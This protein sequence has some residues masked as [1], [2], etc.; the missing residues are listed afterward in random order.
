MATY[1]AIA[2]I[3]AAILAVLEAARPKPEFERATF[4]AFLASDFASP[5]DEGVSLYLYRIGASSRRNLAPRLGPNGEKYR[6]P[7]PVDLYYLLTAWA[8]TAEKQQRL[9]GFCLR[10]LG[11]LPILPAALLNHAG[12]EH[13]VFHPDEC[14]ELVFEPVSLQ[15]LANL[16][17]P[18]K[19]NLQASTTYVARMVAIESDVTVSEGAPV[20][21]RA[22][23]FRE[24]SAAG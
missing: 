21:T 7:L 14:V 24:R 15:D 11:D 6:P 20:Q 2:Q 16:W 23:D 1:Q 19:P 4:K 3:S 22:L 9:L 12:P 8:K 18:L 10:E 5:M 17:E 13:D